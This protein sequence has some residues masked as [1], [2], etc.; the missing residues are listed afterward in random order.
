MIRM[1]KFL[2]KA[3]GV[4]SV[5]RLK[6]ILFSHT[7]LMEASEF[8]DIDVTEDITEFFDTFIE[9]LSASKNLTSLSILDKNLFLDISVLFNHLNL[10]KL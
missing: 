7:E 3:Y 9:A 4:S 1:N 2:E 10:S 8:I 6:E 5:H